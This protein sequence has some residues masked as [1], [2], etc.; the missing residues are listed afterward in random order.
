MQ[1]VKLLPSIKPYRNAQAFPL[2]QS[3]ESL[4]EESVGPL[5]LLAEAGDL[6]GLVLGYGDG[7]DDFR[8]K[9]TASTSPRTDSVPR[10]SFTIL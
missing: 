7:G 8:S 2:F 3:A 10:L 5:V 6:P 4:F 9:F 1:S